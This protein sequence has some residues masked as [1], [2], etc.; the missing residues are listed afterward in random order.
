[1]YTAVAEQGIWKPDLPVLFMSTVVALRTLHSQWYLNQFVR[2]VS[3][4]IPILRMGVE[5]MTLWQR[6]KANQERT[7]L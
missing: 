7:D 2:Q 5:F 6:D 3:M 1:M 4:I